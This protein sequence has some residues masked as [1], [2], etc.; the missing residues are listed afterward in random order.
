MRP[1]C[2]R[3][4][5]TRS[6][7]SSSAPQLNT[8]RSRPRVRAGSAI[9]RN[10]ARRSAFD[11]DLGLLA[12]PRQ[13]QH[14]RRPG[15]GSHRQFGARNIARRDGGEGQPLD[16]AVETLRDHSPDRPKAADRDA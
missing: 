5:S 3:A 14:R 1:R 10:S 13:R 2:R 12:E 9:S 8:M 16:P 15:E 11:D 6:K 7:L 4:N